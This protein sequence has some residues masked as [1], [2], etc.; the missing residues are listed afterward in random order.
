MFWKRKSRK[1]ENSKQTLQQLALRLGVER[2][3]HQRIRYSRSH[4]GILPSISFNQ[5]AIPVH[6]LSV[7]GCCL[8]DGDGH[9]GVKIGTEVSL[10]LNLG[11]VVHN[12]RSRIV[13]SV[14]MRRHIQFLDLTP[15][16]AKELANNIQFGIWGLSLRKV[17]HNE[18]SN[19]NLTVSAEEIWTSLLGH[20]VVIENQIHR[21]AQ[22]TLSNQVF[23]IYKEAWPVF[24]NKKPISKLDLERL[25][26]FL[27]NIPYS[28]PH[29]SALLQQ[30]ESI[31]EQAV[32]P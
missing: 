8:I 6:D 4:L 11:N 10:Q 9:L 27:N 29:L 25:I 21:Q 18:K 3:Q 13:S 22:I 1:I 28:T 24:P 20:N 7:G 32:A 14:D 12:V 30:L 16:V 26:L 2:R 19:D 15:E 5:H 23:H 17:A 31:N